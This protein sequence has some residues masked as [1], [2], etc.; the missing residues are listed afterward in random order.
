LSQIFYNILSGFLYVDSTILR[1]SI[2]NT[3]L[4]IKVVKLKD[5][6]RWLGS[7]ERIASLSVPHL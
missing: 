7:W 1:L 3:S 2:E 5:E 6:P 4:E